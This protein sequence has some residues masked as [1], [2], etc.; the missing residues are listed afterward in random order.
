MKSERISASK[1]E[2]TEVDGR[3]CLRIQVLAYNANR[4]EK[5]WTTVHWKYYSTRGRAERVQAE[6]Y[7]THGIVEGGIPALSFRQ[8]FD[9]HGLYIESIRVQV[10]RANLINA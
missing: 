9:K 7:K 8:D 6:F 1:Y 5:Y 4:D 10:D 3:F 2:I